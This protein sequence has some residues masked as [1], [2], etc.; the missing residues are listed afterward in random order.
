MCQPSVGWKVTQGKALSKV[1]V[2]T[3]NL[4]NLKMENE[5][6]MKEMTFEVVFDFCP[7]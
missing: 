5:K 3:L 2:L 6:E 7:G 4:Y 1:P